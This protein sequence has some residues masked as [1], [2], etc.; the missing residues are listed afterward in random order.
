MKNYFRS[1]FH[2]KNLVNTVV[3][4]G[5]KMEVS[6]HLTDLDRPLKPQEVEAPRISVQSALRPAYQRGI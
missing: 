4:Y 5:L 2:E 1:I 6:C 3:C